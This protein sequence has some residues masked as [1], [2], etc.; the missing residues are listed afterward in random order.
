VLEAANLGP[1]SRV[2]V[3]SGPTS[4]S[5]FLAEGAV[6]ELFLTSAPIFVGRA[7]ETPTLALV[8]GRVFRPW[9]LRSRLLSVRRSGDY[10]FLRYAL[11]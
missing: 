6:D 4:T 8:E 9:A 1:G 3:E 11:A 2:L 5:R 10:L 7:S